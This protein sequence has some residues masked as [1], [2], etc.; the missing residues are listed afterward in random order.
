M[1]L[2]T[3]ITLNASFVLVVEKDATFQRLI[4][5]KFL[6]KY[7]A[8]L[9]TGKGSPDINTRQFLNL[10]YKKYSNLLNFYCLTDS[11]PYGKQQFIFF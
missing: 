9:I 3:K 11:N 10:I 5:D 6:D 1:N 8:I 7:S 2:V 4:D